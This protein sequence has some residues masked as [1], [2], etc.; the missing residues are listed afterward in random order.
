MFVRTRGK[1]RSRKYGTIK[2]PPEDLRMRKRVRILEDRGRKEELK[3]KEQIWNGI[4]VD[5]KK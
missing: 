4:Q 1:R 5:G 3:K 2:Q